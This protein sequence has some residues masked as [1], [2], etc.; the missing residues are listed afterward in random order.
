MI[1]FITGAT[2]FIGTRLALELAERGHQVRALIRDE[3][4][5]KPLLENKNIQCYRGSLEDDIILS[6]AM[7]GADGVFH[8]AAYAKPWAK[9]PALYNRINL[10]GTVNIFKIAAAKKV[11]RVVYT[12]TAGTF[13]P[14]CDQPVGEHSLRYKDFFNEYESTKFMGEKKAKDFVIDGMDIVIVH[15]S[16]VYGP[17]FLSKSNGV[18]LLVKKYMQGTWWFIPG[19]G[20]SKGN[21]AYIDDVVN[22][23]ILAMQ[24]GRNG[25]QYIL[26]G[27]NASYWDF[28]YL[29][30][31]ISHKKYPLIPI[32][33]IFL[34]V[35]TALQMA[36]AK[37]FGRPPLL[38]P[39][40]VKKYLYNWELSSA[41]AEGELGYHITPMNKGLHITIEWIKNSFSDGAKA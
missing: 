36:V 17:G 38:P 29:I 10:A 22:G 23:H 2:G 25:E 4:K 37:I 24:K 19:S 30:R 31:D 14:S 6:E 12:S 8:L 20:K 39:K 28:F 40:W 1:Y 5:A 13:G 33:V 41:K 32:P 26:G 18:T 11:K 34:V 16:R 7:Q 27:E 9:D 15:P 21:Y 35:F 3:S